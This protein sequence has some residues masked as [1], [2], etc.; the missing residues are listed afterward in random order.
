MSLPRTIDCA[1]KELVELVTAYLCT[2]LS[3]P[4]RLLVERHLYVCADC[5]MF[6]KQMRTTIRLTATLGANDRG[7]TDIT[8]PS[9]VILAAFRHQ[10]LQNEGA[11]HVGL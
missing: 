3:T 11:G 9:N 10:S 1:C 5:A 8:F 6:L 7:S 2:A 4:E